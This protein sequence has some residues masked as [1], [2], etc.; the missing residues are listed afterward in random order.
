MKL[1][2]LSWKSFWGD[3]RFGWYIECSVMSCVYLGDMFDIY[4][5][6]V[7][8]SFLY[9]ECEIVQSEVFIGECF[10]KYWLYNG[11]ICMNNE[12]MFKFLNNFFIL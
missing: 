7:D 3:G 10:V 6:G 9:Y 8:L 4:G 2:E 11:F 5:G 12:K 1:G